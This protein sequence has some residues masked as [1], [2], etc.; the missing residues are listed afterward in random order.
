MLGLVVAGLIICLTMIFFLLKSPSKN[1]N[2]SKREPLDKKKE[3]EKKTIEK[4]EKQEEEEEESPKIPKIDISKYLFKTIKEGND[5]KKCYF[6]NK[7]HII[8]FCDERKLC[9]CCLKRL[10]SPS[11]KVYSKNIDKDTIADVCFSPE[12]KTVF[13]ASKNSKSIILYNLEKIDGKIK[14]NKSDK[15]I[16]CDRPYEIQSLVVTNNGLMISTI[17][18]NDDTEIQIYNSVS[19]DL[20]YKISTGAIKNFQI[21]MGP[22]DSD[23]L[24]STFMNDISVVSFEKND[25]FNSE[26]K[27]Y[28]SVYKFKRNSS[29]S[30]VK[31]KLLYY[32][33]S[34]DEK[35]FAISGDDKTIKI[36]RNYGNI[37]ES[38]YF[39]HISLD[40]NASIVALYVDNFENGR[41]SGYIGAAEG[42]NA[43]VYDCNGKLLLELPEAHDAN[44]ISL[45]IAKVDFSRK[46]S[47]E[48][49]ESDDKN[50]DFCLISAG[51]D[52]KIKFWKIIN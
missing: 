3:I 26:E 9:L 14:L 44:I 52:G 27:K 34:N 40:F 18:T 35:F 4:E 16:K 23:L 12:K 31:A 11:H 49:E 38:K 48:N 50:G 41:L 46:E 47:V 19:L 30:G 1:D 42:S 25:K 6:Y 17:G 45:Y 7:G 8:L 10:N 24:I 28:E 29:I 43:Y 2:E 33:L 51:T 22:N 37:C 13:C 36:F 15:I 32:C 39:S 5:M 20:Q 21:L